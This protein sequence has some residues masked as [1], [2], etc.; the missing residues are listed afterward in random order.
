M[1]DVARGMPRAAGGA[2]LW[3]AAPCYPG[4]AAGENA[5]EPARFLLVG[6]HAVDQHDRVDVTFPAA[7]QGEIGAGDLLRQHPERKDVAAIR[8][9]TQAAGIA[10]N[11]SAE[12]AGIEEVAEVVVRGPGGLVVVRGAR[13]AFLARDSA[14][15]GDENAAV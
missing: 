11:G 9:E 5:G 7:C 3:L 1:I 10:R 4:L 15:A 8:T 13:G 14:N 12:E 6:A 2:G